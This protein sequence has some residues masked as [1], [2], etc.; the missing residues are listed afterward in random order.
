MTEPDIT[1]NPEEW[2]AAQSTTPPPNR[3][4]QMLRDLG[5]YHGRRPD[6][7]EP[8]NPDWQTSHPHGALNFEHSLDGILDQINEHAFDQ[9]RVSRHA[10]P[11]AGAVDLAVKTAN[12][13]FLNDTLQQMPMVSAIVLSQ[14]W[15]ETDHDAIIRCYN[16]CEGFVRYACEHQGHAQVIGIMR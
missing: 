14:D 8:I 3:A 7:P 12:P 15:T 10:P 9:F 16:G 4:N 2:L 1:T 6:R 13:N 11:P 5:N